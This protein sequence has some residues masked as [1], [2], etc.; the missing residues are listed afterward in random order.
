MAVCQADFEDDPTQRCAGVTVTHLISPHK[1]RDHL[2]RKASK[3]LHL[4]KHSLLDGTQCANIQMV[5]KYVKGLCLLLLTL[6]TF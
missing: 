4:P 1:G 3:A 5:A 2:I 6:V